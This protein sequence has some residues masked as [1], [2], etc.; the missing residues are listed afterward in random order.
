MK[1]A[2]Q[3]NQTKLSFIAEEQ[4]SQG[5]SYI[6]RNWLFIFEAVGLLN[7]LYRWNFSFESGR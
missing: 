5:S 6:R 3:R 1:G 4:S 7:W 2:A